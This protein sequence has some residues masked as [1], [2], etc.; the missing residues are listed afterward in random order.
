MSIKT[1]A[2][3]RDVSTGVE[4][5]S[6]L[7][8][9]AG[10]LSLGQPVARGAS[11]IEKRLAAFRKVEPFRG[12][13]LL[14]VGCG[15][16]AYTI[17]LT[18][19]FAMVVAIDVEPER[20]KE[21]AMV[22][23][24]SVRSGSID[25]R[26]MSAEAIEFPDE[27][28]DAVTAIEV[29]EHVTDLPRALAE[30]ARVLKPGGH[31]Y[32][33]APNRRFPFETHSVRIPGRGEID[34]RLLPLL[35]YVSP[36]HRRISTARNFTAGELTGLAAGAGLLP[37]GIG[38]VMP[39]F[40]HWRFGRRWLKPVTE[41]LER[42]ALG[43]IG[44]SI[45][46]VFE[47]APREPISQEQGEVMS[48]TEQIDIAG[49]PLHNVT[50]EQTVQ[51]IVEWARDETGGYVYTPNVDDIVKARRIPEFRA[52]VLGARLRVPDGM[53][54]VYGSRI[55]GKPLR[56]TVTGRLLPAAIARSLAGRP[57]GVAFFGGRPEV[58]KAAAQAI[59]DEGGLV[60]AAIS[61]P[62]GFH[63][64]SD[65]DVALTEQLRASGAGVVFVSLGAPRQALWMARH[66]RDL[67]NA[68]L[69][70]V[71]AA[72]DVLAGGVP[73]A[74]AW[75]TRVGLEWAFR[76][77]NEPRRLA[78]R[79]LFEDPRFFLWVIKQRFKRS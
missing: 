45:V 14:D 8:G 35:P 6:P 21:F 51:K 22:A 54:V 69:V 7:A 68:V 4:S 23:D 9:R 31:L 58:V 24:A 26:R 77:K 57:P 49:I 76:L 71:G 13:R 20:L 74:P 44:V 27:S 28:F 34:G 55:L 56:G 66:A 73:A 43:V 46:A 50:F 67:P 65:E 29:L 41:R 33:S 47:K 53:G 2:S 38:H 78:R 30:I 15:N 72:V 5:V 32:V 11:G 1:E 40:D 17:E 18:K 60:T 64:G 59:T 42:S 25:I 39:P 63:V 37:R 62:M 36:L 19:E 70:G 61:P 52:A 3:D 75:M 48:G 12:G 79:Y 10:G 16:G